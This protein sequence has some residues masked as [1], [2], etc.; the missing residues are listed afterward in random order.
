MLTTGDRVK[1]LNP[2]TNEVDCVEVVNAL[3]QDGYEQI[4]V[5][6]PDGEVIVVREGAIHNRF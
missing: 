3:Y 1:V 6:L 2:K 4:E 5:K